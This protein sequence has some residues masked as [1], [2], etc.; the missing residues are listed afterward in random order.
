MLRCRFR[1]GGESDSD[2]QLIRTGLLQ[3]GWAED[4]IEAISFS[5]PVGSN[6]EHAVELIRRRSH[7]RADRLQRSRRA[8]ALM[9][10]LAAQGTS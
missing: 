8:G 7:V 3:A 9:G 2:L 4:R 1:A 5:D 6:R 10:G